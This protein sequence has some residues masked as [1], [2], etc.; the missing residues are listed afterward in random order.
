MAITVSQGS[1]TCARCKRKLTNP[2]SVARSLGPV[3]YSKSGGGAFDADLQADEKEWARRE[4]LLKA[5]GEID[6]GVNWEYP[7]PGNMIASYNMRVSVRYREGAYEAYGHITLA[8]K[9]AQEIVFAR[10]QDLKVIYREAVAAG[11]TYTAMA[12]RARQEAGRE[13]M[14][15]WRQS[16]K[17]RM[18]G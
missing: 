7:D 15:Q 6:L 5:G 11:P 9:E 2:H 12:Y 18:A 3:C 10:G 17:E 8:G 1:G 13:A 4:Q 16:R 14:R